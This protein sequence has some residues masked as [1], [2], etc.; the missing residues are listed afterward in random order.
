MYLSRSVSSSPGVPISSADCAVGC[1][2]GLAQ[3]HQRRLPFRAARPTDRFAAIAAVLERFPQRG[4]RR[5]FD[6]TDQLTCQS[7]LENAMFPNP[8][9]ALFLILIGPSRRRSSGALE[10]MK[11]SKPVGITIATARDDHVGLCPT[12]RYGATPSRH[13][14]SINNSMPLRVRSFCSRRASVSGTSRN[15][16]PARSRWSK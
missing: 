5:Q 7:D 8:L 3:S 6:A 9:L 14:P 2:A 13:H 15:S 10:R 11:L 16:N 4:Q 1:E 12:V